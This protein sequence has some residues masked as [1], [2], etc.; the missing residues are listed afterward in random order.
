MLARVLGRTR[1]IGISSALGASSRMIF[2]LFLTESLVL[3]LIGGLL[4]LA[5]A[6]GI[7]AGLESTLK[8]AGDFSVTGMDL[9]LHPIHFGLG[10]LVALGV[11]LLFGAYPAW[12]ASRVRPSEAL[13]G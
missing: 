6:R 3:G 1:S 8:K 7:T 10:L 2:L 13:R 12:M 11:S 4:G 9:S 5:L